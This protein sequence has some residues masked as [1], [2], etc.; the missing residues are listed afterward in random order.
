L[1]R[2]NSVTIRTR[3]GFPSA[4]NTVAARSSASVRMSNVFIA[5]Q[6]SNLIGNLR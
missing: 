4:R 2:A 5:H 6:C 1:R 3:A